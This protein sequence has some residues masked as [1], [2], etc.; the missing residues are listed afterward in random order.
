MPNRAGPEQVG[1][2][3]IGLHHRI[4]TPP[5][6]VAVYTHARHR[7]RHRY[8][9]RTHRHARARTPKLSDSNPKLVLSRTRTCLLQTGAIHPLKPLSVFVLPR[10]AYY[11]RVVGRVAYY[12]AMTCWQWA[13]LLAT[14]TPDA[15][16]GVL[17]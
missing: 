13:H 3:L 4:D 15:L 9:Q 16:S 8:R 11:R 1:K 17:I 7:H 5:A 12:N 2:L 6:P 14:P 10:V